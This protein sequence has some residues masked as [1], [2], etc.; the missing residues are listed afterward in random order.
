MNMIQAKSISQW[1][2]LYRLYR[3]AFPRY[4]R[5]PFFL[6]HSMQKKGKSDVWYFEKDNEFVGLAITINGDDIILV[7]YL[8]LVKDKRGQGIGSEILR[9]LQSHYSDKGL[10][11]EIESV[12][13]KAKNLSERRRRKEFYLKNGMVCMNVMV[14][15][16][17]VEMELLGANC[18][19]TY[20]EYYSLYKENFGKF[21]T[22][23]ITKA[24]HPYEN[25]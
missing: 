12:Y 15:L 13:K 2:K 22:K 23:K 10:L 11:I 25:A 1:I 6:I 5:K 21:I 19:V 14:N 20:E 3:Q 8:A 7:D 9:M 4:E 24:R 18:L 16:F 17:G